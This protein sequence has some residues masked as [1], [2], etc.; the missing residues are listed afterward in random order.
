MLSRLMTRR[1]QLVILFTGVSLVIGSV[2]AYWLNRDTTTPPAIPLN[3]EPV[4]EAEIASESVG[5][6][7]T[8]TQ[9]DT[10][11]TPTTRIVV[12]VRGA[13]GRPGVYSMD[14]SDRVD[15]VI[16][17]S[18]GLL[19]NSD[20]TDINLAAKLIDGS[21]LTI[22]ATRSTETRDGIVILRKERSRPVNNPPD[23]TL[24]GW[25]QP[26]DAGSDGSD[27]GETRLVAASMDTRVDLN[28]AS[29]DQLQRLPG[30]GPVLA[31]QIVDYRSNTP[32]NSVEQ[33]KDVR[34]IGPK[35]FETIR[36]LVTVNP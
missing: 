8:I 35:R 6:P 22:P 33:L 13:V 26:A 18:G 11:P 7:D 1:E 15:D 2:T 17:R 24:S 32:F 29:E 21:T 31:Q 19:E 20:V 30:I 27:P 12:S 23:Y 25:T 34:G 3:S 4:S 16:A 14:A 5:T 28:Q 36:E 10:M 9:R